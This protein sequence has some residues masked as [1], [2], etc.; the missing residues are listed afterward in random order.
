[1]KGKQRCKILKELRQQIAEQNDIAYVTSECKHQG[2]CKGTCPKCESEVRYLERELEKRVRLGKAVTLVGLAAG[3]TFASVGCTAPDIFSK[4]NELDG[5]MAAPSEIVSDSGNSEDSV[6]DPVGEM[7]TSEF[8]PEDTGDPVNWNEDDN[9]TV[10][11]GDA[12][13]SAYFENEN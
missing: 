6:V 2:D 13:A 7:P 4:N 5:D 8:V 3:I 10:T 1:M 11:Q 9:A 12:P